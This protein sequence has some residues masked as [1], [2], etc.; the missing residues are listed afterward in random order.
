V[1]DGR[2]RPAVHKPVVLGLQQSV[3]GQQKGAFA[4]CTGFWNPLAAG[5]FTDRNLLW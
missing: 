4:F 3:L 1:S 5:R 2:N